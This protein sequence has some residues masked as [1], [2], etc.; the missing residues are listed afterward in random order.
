[1]LSIMFI[2]VFHVFISIS[3]FFSP[4]KKVMKRKDIKK[5]YMIYNK[6]ERENK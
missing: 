5:R 4:T 2:V 1:M 3:G 6:P